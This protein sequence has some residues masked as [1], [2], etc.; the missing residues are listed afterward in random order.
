MTGQPTEV[1]VVF[2]R[3]SAAQPLAQLGTVRAANDDLACSYARTTYDED[4][5]IELVVVPRGAMIPA[6]RT[7]ITT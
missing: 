3:L 2:G 4:R 5:W 7:E 1:Y 6:L